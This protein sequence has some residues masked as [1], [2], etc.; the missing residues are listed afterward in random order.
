MR[1]TVDNKI[2][3][4]A[5][6]RSSGE[7]PARSS[8]RFLPPSASFRRGVSR[9][10]RGRARSR[11]T[12]RG[13]K[14]RPTILQTWD[15]WGTCPPAPRSRSQGPLVPPLPRPRKNGA[16]LGRDSASGITSR[17]RDG[18]AAWRPALLV[19]FKYGADNDYETRGQTRKWPRHRS[20]HTQYAHVRRQTA[21]KQAGRQARTH[22]RR[23]DSGV[24]AAAMHSRELHKINRSRGRESVGK[25]ARRD[26]G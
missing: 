14:S 3:N 1:K 19:E 24:L 22:A 2:L 5:T 18:R 21:G 17:H 13:R 26:A 23:G 9:S 20:P 25:G 7:A 6:R 10:P 4:P 8:A 15:T 11:A 12:S 16:S